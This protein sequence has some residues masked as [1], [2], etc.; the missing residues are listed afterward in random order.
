M[1]TWMRWALAGFTAVLAATA[2][3]G[4]PVE[5]GQ[6]GRLLPP[7]DSSGVE[8]DM[9]RDVA[10][11]RV[12]A[13]QG[14]APG[15]LRVQWWG[16][17]WPAGG[18]GGWM[19]LDDPWNGSWVNA[20]GTWE[21]Q[22]P[23]GIAFRFAPLAGE[24]W[25]HALKAEQYPGGAAPAFRKTLKVRVVSEDEA[26]VRGIRLEVYGRS[27]WK[28]AQFDIETRLA[29]DR[30]LAMQPGAGTQPPV[31][32][33]A[34]ASS[35]EDVVE[36]QYWFATNAY[37]Y[38]GLKRAAQALAAIGHGDAERF[39][40]EAEAYRRA[41]EAAAR[42]AATRSAAVPLRDGMYIPYVPSRVYQWRHLTEGWIREALYC[43]LHLAAA[44]VVDPAEGPASTSGCLV[45][46]PR[47]RVH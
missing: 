44:E 45:K 31:H 13:G 27:V 20:V 24:E 3:A 28:E 29:G 12:P 7:E 19:R 41:I 34:P 42:E 43:A 22:A 33:L 1:C 11:L 16:S 9:P 2:A 15:S 35:L 5:I 10:E 30:R 40:A 47:R 46:T 26:P 14:A 25:P 32:G 23:G 21:P 36:Y 18:T 6:F 8:W 4:E 38:L 17:V 37:F 39:G